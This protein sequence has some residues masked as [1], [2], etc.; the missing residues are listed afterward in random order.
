MEP[1]DPDF[2]F[3]LLAEL[4]ETG[5]VPGYEDRIRDLVRERF[6]GVA[7]EVHTDAMGNV[8][9]T[10]TPGADYA[11]AVAAHM[12]EIGFMVRH[13]N[14]EGFLELDPLGGWDARVMRAQRVT[15]HAEDGYLP[16]VI[17]S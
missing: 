3:E 9:G 7:D 12:D 4:T 6:D 16:G 10:V 5:G 2:D 1:G 14:D 17:G 13:V 11:V 8:V 15:V